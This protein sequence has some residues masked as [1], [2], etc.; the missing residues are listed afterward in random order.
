MADSI[1]RELKSHR[2]NRLLAALPPVEFKA[3]V[4]MLREVS[5]RRRQILAE[6]GEP[7]EHVYFP[8]QGIVSLIVMTEEGRVA[9]AAAIG[10]EGVVGLG[11]ILG[12]NRSYARNIV[13]ISGTASRI[14]TERFV[15]ALQRHPTFK[16]IILRYAGAF[17]FQILRST[18]C[19]ALHSIEERAARW[20]LTAHD[21]AREDTFDLTQEFFQKCSAFDVPVSV[22]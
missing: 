11:T 1:H 21:R 18:A 16:Q 10:P 12:S 17:I 3:L 9:E 22:L 13:Q 4:P 19:N 7:F 8:H 2:D 15:E 14:S 5:L 20:L 6:E